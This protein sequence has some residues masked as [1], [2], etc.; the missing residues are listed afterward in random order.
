MAVRLIDHDV[1]VEIA[2]L[3]LDYFKALVWPLVVLVIVL[4]FRA[5][6]AQLFK[7]IRTLSTPGVDAEFS[8]EVS[9]VSA[10]T[11]AAVREAPPT[12]SAQTGRGEDA[13][14]EWPPST[15]PL[16][17]ALSPT[18]GMLAAWRHVERLL[19]QLAPGETRR[20]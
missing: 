3:V 20:G 5:E 19:Y 8:D 7:R 4:R 13:S 2:R 16:I 12:A 11:E 1:G 6:I 17:A 18:A 9:E 14:G 10:E 15:L